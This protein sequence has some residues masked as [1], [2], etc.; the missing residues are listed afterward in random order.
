MS[1]VSESDPRSRVG[2]WYIPYGESSSQYL[3]CQA[4]QDSVTHT[5]HSSKRFVLSLQW[6][7]SFT[8]SGN[9]TILATLVM[10]Y[11]TYWTNVTS[12]VITV[13]SE[14]YED[15]KVYGGQYD[16][17]DYDYFQEDN[18]LMESVIS[19]QM[20]VDFQK[21]STEVEDE[22]EVRAVRPS[23]STSPEPEPGVDDGL[24]PSGPEARTGGRR[25]S[26]Y[27]SVLLWPRRE[28]TTTTTTAT[29]TRTVGSL[30]GSWDS[31]TTSRTLDRNFDAWW[32]LPVTIPASRDQEGFFRPTLLADRQDRLTTTTYRSILIQRRKDSQSTKTKQ[33]SPDESV[34]PSIKPWQEDGHSKENVNIP[35]IISHNKDNI[36]QNSLETNI[37]QSV[38]ESFSKLNRLIVTPSNQN[39]RK[40]T[41]KTSNIQEIDA[42]FNDNKEPYSKMNAEHGSWDNSSATKHTCYT[43]ILYI[44]YLL[45]FLLMS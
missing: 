38:T 36:D 21:R 2:S 37:V 28:K 44:V 40:S 19:T 12:N 27:R 15:I 4:V 43:R 14:E 9:V 18:S 29:I 17:G 30:L 25:D 22:P 13:M 23:V 42:V 34:I 31:T 7:P 11:R 20:L 33:T 5:A 16:F 35:I 8:F 3:H 41:Y 39:V 24:A 10:D 1:A 6:K 26:T 45:L 32:R